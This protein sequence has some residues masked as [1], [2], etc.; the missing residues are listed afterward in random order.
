MLRNKGLTEKVLMLG[1]DGMDPKFSRKMVDEG[2]MPNLKKLIEHGSA[3]H[4]L[5][6][7][8]AVPTITPPMWTT[9]ATGAYPMTH[10]IEDFQINLEGELDINFIGIYSKH[11]KAQ[12]LWNITAEAGKKTLVWHWPG[13]AWPPSTNNENLYVVDGTFAG[14][15]GHGFANRD[16]EGVLIGSSK[17]ESTSFYPAAV[18]YTADLSGTT[19]E[20]TG[21]P[22]FF[23]PSENKNYW[24]ELWNEFKNDI[25]GFN[26]YKPKRFA[27]THTGFLMDGQSM[28]STLTA[29]PVDVTLSSITTPTGWSINIPN[30]AKEFTFLF[31]GGNIERPCLILKNEQGIYDKIA[32][33]ISKNEQEPITILKKDVFTFPVL[34]VIELNNGTKENVAR[35]MRIL[36]LAENASFIRIWFSNA[37]STDDN[38]ASYPSWILEKVKEQFGPIVPTGSLGGGDVNILNKCNLEQWYYAAKW[39]ANSIN[40]MI[41]EENI[42]VVFSH[43]HGPDMSGHPYMKHLKNRISSKTDEKEIYQCAVGTY[44]MTDAYIGEFLPLLDEGWTILLFSDHSLICPTEDFVPGLGDGYA[45]NIDFMREHGYTVM[46]K[47][48]NGNDLPEIDWDKTTA[49]ATGSNF[50]FIN[51]KGRDR[52]GIVKLED[53]YELEEKIITD[54]YGYKDPKTGHR[55]VALALHRKDANLLGVGGEH[56]SGDIIY[57]IHESFVHDHGESLSTAEG[58]ADTSVGPIFVAAGKGIKE[59]YELQLF[60]REV[61]I[62]PTAAV[63]L[64]VSI[65]AQ[66]EGAPVYSILNEEL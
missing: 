47:D 23:T 4:D 6:L 18:T 15:L 10:G 1:I 42:D 20:L 2:Y 45:I 46:K 25:D 49:I 44:K 13:A 5:R 35:S 29:W 50:I 51:L 53:K 32:M 22:K 56:T 7:L 41:H 33:Y 59:N 34:D 28:M 26:G 58:Y 21:T 55:V 52:F 31:K 43:F 11:C 27:N 36:D 16:S 64:G 60:P 40:Y 3:R 39:Q 61:D 8:G 14:A 24:K 63:L 62:A 30:N 37:I 65:P 17:T 54:L 12:Q 19:E 9:L 66:C 38:T 48:E 57:Y